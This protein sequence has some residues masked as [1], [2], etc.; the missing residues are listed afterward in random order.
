MTTEQIEI[1]RKLKR[2]WLTFFG[3]YGKNLPIQLM[4]IP[5]I[6]NS[7]NVLIISPT[8]SGKTEAVVAP[9]CERFFNE[10]WRNISIL[11]ISP[12]RA[13]INDLYFRLKDQ[14]Q[15]LGISISI[16][17][18]D[19]P[20][21]DPNKV[22]NFLIT[23]PESLDS[24]LCRHAK[25][26][27][28][29]RAVVLDEIHLIDNT[30]RGDQLRVLLKRLEEIS[31]SA[32]NKYCLSA[33]VSEPEKIGGRYLK[34]F[35]VIL[36]HS[37]REIKYTYANSLTEV[38]KIVKEEHL[39][40]ILIFC[41]KRASVEIISKE[42]K[43]IVGD[44]FVVVHHGSLSRSVR[45]EAENFMKESHYGVC[46]ATM[47]LEIGIDIGDIDAI[48]LA[49]VP[50]SVISLLQR[51]GR[52]NRRS[53]I[54]R[55]IAIYQLDNEKLILKKMF[56]A[57]IAGQLEFTDYEPDMSVAI[58]QIFS[59]LYANPQ[60]VE[61]NYLEKILIELCNIEELRDILRTLADKEWLEKR[62]GKWY[63]TEKLMNF[64]E[65]GNV[66]SNI[67]SNEALI[68]INIDSKEEIGKVYPPLD[69][70]FL[71]NGKA[72][73][74]ISNINNKVYAKPL[75]AKVSKTAFKSYRSQ[76]AFYYLLPKHL[77]K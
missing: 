69:D 4:T 19:R 5:H 26:F 11:Y 73:K 18:G 70:I 47:T 58:Q 12:T 64:G 61:E 51:I 2:T 46:V 74:I 21:F 44:N 53:D 25:S 23:T 56:E 75:H 60:G 13:L 39:K 27:K 40:K 57:A 20:K 6:L 63:A 15:E 49:E 71:L 24:L 8:A 36:S 65:S 52:G 76:G 35:K 17:T 68:V 22:P 28:N 50:L 43:S 55:V 31:D 48:I 72:W 59:I 34:D 3:R 33:T 45:V 7:E 10:D 62:Y 37:K 9:L 32:F 77:Q 38:F 41:N 67:P 66:H 54:S 29:I 42:C 14:L 1:R 16:K 30:Y